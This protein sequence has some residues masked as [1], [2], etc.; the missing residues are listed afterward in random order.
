MRD[1]GFAVAP[2]AHD[3]TTPIGE[4]L[5][6]R[7]QHPSVEDLEGRRLLAVVPPVLSLTPLPPQIRAEVP[8]AFH[9]RL[10]AHPRRLEQQMLKV[11]RSSQ[12]SRAELKAL[13]DLPPSRAAYEATQPHW[14]AKTILAAPIVLPIFAVAGLFHKGI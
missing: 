4:L 5:M 12:P 2:G 7:S 9:S 8:A 13:H 6:I 1:I 11:I 3:A 10:P 14:D